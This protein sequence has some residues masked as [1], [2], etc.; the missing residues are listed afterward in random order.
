MKIS[1]YQLGW[2]GIRVA[3]AGRA[4]KILKRDGWIKMDPASINNHNAFG[5]MRPCRTEEEYLTTDWNYLA[6]AGLSGVAMW[7]T[8]AQQGKNSSVTDHQWQRRSLIEGQFNVQWPTGRR[9]A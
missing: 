7:I 4:S 1:A 9:A 2:I 6:K 5:W 3:K 8:K